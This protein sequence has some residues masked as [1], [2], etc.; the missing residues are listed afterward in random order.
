MKLN[1][2]ELT[3]L[4]RFLFD[5]AM[6]IPDN[7]RTVL[8][9]I[10]GKDVALKY[11][12]QTEKEQRRSPKERFIRMD[13]WAQDEDDTIYDAEVQKTN[14]RNLPKRSRYYQSLIDS[15]LLTP[16]VIDFNNLN[17]VFII[18]IAPFDLF[19]EDRYVYTFS[20]QCEEV[21]G[22]K[23]QDGATRIFLNTHGK[24]HDGITPELRELLYFM[25][26]TNDSD[27]VIRNDGIRRLH[28]SVRAIQDNE[29]IGVKYMQAWEEKIMWEQEAHAKGLEEGRAEG[30]EEGRAEGREEG[31][32]EGR[33]EGRAEGRE[34]GRAEGREE[35]RK[36]VR[37]EMLL[38]KVRRKLDRHLSVEQIADA[39]EE[40][41]E[42]IQELIRKL[43]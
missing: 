29:E 3:L 8:E 25:E 27:M 42:R 21:A 12:P 35:A 24:D 36:E 38:D 32:A 1:L 39:L 14:T 31:R 23:L 30:R 28:D 41:P 4:D 7:M 6:E 37:E 10:L 22:L 18:I 13:V 20:M 40:S 33:E 17:A 5:E 15:K 16:G 26:H 19:G 43:D 2:R 34:E 9:I 11:L